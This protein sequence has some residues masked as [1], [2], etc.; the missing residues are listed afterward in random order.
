MPSTVI[1]SFN[2]DADKKILQI[3]FV[4][5]LVYNYMEVA[6][7]VY[8]SMKASRAKGI[9]FNQHIKDKFA[10]ERQTG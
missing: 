6:P 2:Y 4:T 1:N 5:G 10:F 3:R 8:E 7:E 9:F